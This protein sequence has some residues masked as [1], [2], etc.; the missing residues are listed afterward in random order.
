[1]QIKD[2]AVIITGGG[3]G[4]GAATARLCAAQGAKVAILDKNLEAAEVIAKEIKGIA[5]AC[6]VSD[7]K[8]A[9]NAVK[10]AKEAH[11]P[12]RICVNCAGVAPAKK[13]VGREG[14]MPLDTFNQVIQINLIGSFNLLRLAAAEMSALE[15]CDADNERGVIINTASIA[16]FEG[17]IGQAA[18]S[19]SKAGIV[20]MT[21]PAARELARSNIRV[22]TIA[23]GIIETPLL[24]NMPQEVQNSLATQVPFPKR[25]G[26]TKEF[27]ALVLHIIQNAYLNGSVIRLDGAMRML[28]K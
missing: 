17:Q 4:M 2:K 1:M 9:E 7:A 20:G 23:P 10:I 3:S 11:G 5:I 19:A 24:L 18:Y 8:S 21:L 6:D 27:A 26:Q 14:T 15:P 28:E 13:I 12:A 22:M 16:A 25:M